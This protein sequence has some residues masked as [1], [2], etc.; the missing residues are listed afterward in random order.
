MLNA[1]ALLLTIAGTSR[2]NLAPEC[3]PTDVMR[4]ISTIAA[5]SMRGRAP[6]S[7]GD[8]LSTA[9]L[10]RELE[11]AIGASGRVTFQ[12]VSPSDGSLHSRNIIATVPGLLDEWVLVS[13]HHDGL[14]VGKA[15]ARGDSIY[16]GANDN[17]LGAALAVCI[18]QSLAPAAGHRG[19]IVL[20]TAMEERG[21]LG[22]RYWAE[23]PTVDRS[24]V[25]LGINL[26]ALGVTGPSQ[27]FIAYGNGM[28][29]GA[30]SLLEAAGARAG[31]TLTNAPFE[32]S[33]YWAFDSAELSA[34]GIPAITIGQGMRPPQQA[35]RAPPAGMPAMRQRYHSP[36]DEVAEDW[37]PAAILRYGAL[38]AS[39][40]EGARTNAGTIALR[41]PNVYQSR[42]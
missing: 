23:H 33:M 34:V 22:G 14:G 15:D 24:K 20:L 12:V 25:K 42:P 9:Y 31:F 19:V 18:A 27:D 8:S 36:A 28:L 4:T 37:D 5:D 2:S 35:P 6:G 11:R 16:N 3:T 7:R 1:L 32:S 10:A 39:V 38:V 40:V 26:D 30:D 17:A 41:V 29:T 21:R 13:A